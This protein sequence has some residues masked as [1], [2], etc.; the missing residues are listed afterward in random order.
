VFL[1]GL[2]FDTVRLETCIDGM[3]WFPDLNM[4][5]TYNSAIKQESYRII[6]VNGDN[7]EFFFNFFL[8]GLKFHDMLGQHTWIDGMG[9]FLDSK[10][11]QT[12]NLTIKHQA[13]RIVNV[14]GANVEFFPVCACMD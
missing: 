6:N 5:C 2:K 4:T 9:G 7:V 1:Y 12:N 11:S 3:G 13:Y 8:Y 10:M 14:N